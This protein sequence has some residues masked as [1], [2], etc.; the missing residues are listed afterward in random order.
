MTKKII[1]I[2]NKTG[3]PSDWILLKRDEGI[4]Y[5]GGRTCPVVVAKDSNDVIQI[6]KEAKK[7]FKWYELIYFTCPLEELGTTP[8]G[9][10]IN[11]EKK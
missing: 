1:Y 11:G 2:K 5:F 3:Y 4:F 10:G 8:K 9:F 7:Y 6:M